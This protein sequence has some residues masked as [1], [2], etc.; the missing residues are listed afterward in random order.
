VWRVLAS[1]IEVTAEESLP[2]G[3]LLWVAASLATAQNDYEAGAALSEESL[4]IG[5]LLGDVTIVGWSL[6]YRTPA[7]W[8]AGKPPE[9]TRLNQTLS[10]ARLMQLPQLELTA[11]DLLAH[12]SMAR[13]ELDRAVEFGGQGLAASKARGELWNRA[14]FLNVLAQ[15]SWQRGDRQRAQSLA[16]RSTTA[17]GFGILVETLAWM[18]AQRAAYEH[19]AALLGLP[20]ASGR[21]ALSRWWGRSGRNATSQSRPP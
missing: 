4:R 8:Y 14:F 6:I 11:M 13:G 15:A 16:T 1:L 17:L 3:R 7:H 19:A 18:A 20:S 2:R 10:L 5:T 12:I 9:A 21:P